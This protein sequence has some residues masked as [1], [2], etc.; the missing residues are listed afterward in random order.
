MR[1]TS[2]TID[3]MPAART[4]FGVSMDIGFLLRGVALG[5]NIPLTSSI[6]Q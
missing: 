1:P 2:A 6:S 5:R 3:E 4:R